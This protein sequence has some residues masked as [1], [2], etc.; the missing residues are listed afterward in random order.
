MILLLR[1]VLLHYLLHLQ[2][3]ETRRR[4]L[5]WIRY[6]RRRYH[7]HPPPP[8]LRHTQEGYV[9]CDMIVGSFFLSKLV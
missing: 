2:P 6:R 4:Y 8:P 9:I 7:Y 3:K 1:R 5:K